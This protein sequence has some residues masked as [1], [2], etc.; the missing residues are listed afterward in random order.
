[1][2]ASSED[3]ARYS[4][5]SLQIATRLGFGVPARCVHILT[6][7]DGVFE[8]IET[9]SG[10]HLGGEDFDRCVVDYLVD[11]Y[12]ADWEP[13]VAASGTCMAGVPGVLWR[14][15]AVLWGPS[16]LTQHGHKGNPELRKCMWKWGESAPCGQARLWRPKRPH[17]D[18]SLIWKETYTQAKISIASAPRGRCDE[19]K[20]EV[21]VRRVHPCRSRT[22]WIA[23]SIFANVAIRSFA[24]R[25]PTSE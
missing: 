12:R 23:P 16:T 3:C 10:T 25:N 7:G 8:V 17:L 22:L 9:S 24:S 2:A 6:I 5:V 11:V 1:M 4:C 13:A 18:R 19:P 21:F 15:P 14:Y 20:S